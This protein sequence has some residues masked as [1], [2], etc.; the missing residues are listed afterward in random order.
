MPH[1]SCSG[2]P[3]LPGQNKMVDPAIL[4]EQQGLKVTPQ[5]YA[6]LQFLQQS[7]S[8]PT[9][10]ELV[11]QL[12]RNLPMTSRATVYNTLSTL[13]DVGLVH[14]VTHEA[15]V[16]RYDANIQPHHHFICRICN[17]FDDIDWHLLDSLD[18]SPIAG[19]YPQI[20]NVEVIVRGV[21]R[22]CQGQG[23]V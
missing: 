16:L 8:H 3:V 23:T 19:R 15:G 9:A 12:N 6:I 14:E 5:R 4:L 2:S 10:D 1:L 17:R 22:Q 20:D 11:E 13:K 7:D 21:C 18:L